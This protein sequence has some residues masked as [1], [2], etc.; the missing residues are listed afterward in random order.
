MRL[1]GVASKT[2]FCDA[3][4]KHNG[5]SLSTISMDR[6]V[7]QE[8]IVLKS[9]DLAIFVLRQIGEGILKMSHMQE[10]FVLP[11]FF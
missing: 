2:N 3:R 7:A 6:F 1:V 11:H 9:R 4:A 8:S 10:V 5:A